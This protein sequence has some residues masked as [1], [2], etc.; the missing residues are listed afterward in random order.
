MIP[1]VISLSCAPALIDQ[2]RIVYLPREL[3]RMGV[4]GSKRIESP[5]FM[6]YR[7]SAALSSQ[8]MNT[9]A[10]MIN[11]V[12]WRYFGGYHLGR[13]TTE[14]IAGSCYFAGNPVDSLPRC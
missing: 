10:P 6:V 1:T 12:A 13:K 5:S 11:Q 14:Q 8:S 7:I 9:D 3:I 4:L 2:A